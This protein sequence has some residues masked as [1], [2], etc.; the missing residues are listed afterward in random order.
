MEQITITL[1]TGNSAFE[2]DLFEG[3]SAVMRTLLKDFQNGMIPKAILDINGNT[4][5]KIEVVE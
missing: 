5:G 1:N 4:I 2:E 3:L